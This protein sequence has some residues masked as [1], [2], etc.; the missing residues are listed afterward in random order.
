MRHIDRELIKA[1]V[2]FEISAMITREF[3]YL[4]GFPT[5]TTLGTA[6]FHEVYDRY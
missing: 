3:Q 4:V 5:Q 2:K 6:S 1:Q